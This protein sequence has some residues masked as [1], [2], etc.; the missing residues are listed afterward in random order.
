MHGSLHVA[1]FV[2]M[3][4]QKTSFT[5][6]CELASIFPKGI[7]EDLLLGG[8]CPSPPPNRIFPIDAL[9]SMVYSDGFKHGADN[10]E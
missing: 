5:N 10:D 3:A 2:V 1:P 8:A 9:K 4:C 6:V 7:V